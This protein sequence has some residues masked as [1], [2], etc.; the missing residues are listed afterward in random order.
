VDVQYIYDCQIEEAEILVLNKSDLLPPAAAREV[1]EAAR[2]RYPEKTILLQSS[3]DQADIQR[4][5][6]MLNVKTEGIG[7]RAIPV[8]Y[9]RYSH[10]ETGLAWYDA[11]LS[12]DLS[13]DRGSE[14]ANRLVV[15]LR[16]AV[17]RRG[18]PVG[19][20]KVFLQ[21]Q[22]GSLAVSI[23]DDP[24]SPLVMQKVSGRHLD[25]VINARAEDSAEGLLSAIR[26][27]T[28]RALSGGGIAWAISNEE[29]FHPARPQPSQR[30]P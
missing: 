26:E 29:S 2:A 3:F 27:G 21:H 6:G 18:R 7:H 10:G 19:H 1:E 5:T 14:T 12:V 22:A 8:D 20:L 11:T 25:V 13:E 4:W 17:R 9:D 30:M 23:T 28:Q 16:D 15:E 24:V